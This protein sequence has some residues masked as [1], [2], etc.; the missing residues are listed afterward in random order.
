MKNTLRGIAFCAALTAC[1]PS[2]AAASVW[3]ADDDAARCQQLAK[4]DFSAIQDASSQVTEAKLVAPDGDVPAYCDVRGYVNPSVGIGLK[5]PVAN[6]NG[7][8]LEMGCGGSCGTLFSSYSENLG[9][10]CDQ[11]LRKGYA[12]VATD[13]GHQG[14]D[15]AWSKNNLQAQIDYAF[16]AVHVTSI[17]GKAIAGRYYGKAPQKSYF[18]GC[19]DGG[20]EAMNEAQKFPW[21]FDGIVSVA[22]VTDMVGFMLSGL[23]RDRVAEHDGKALFTDA[24]VE[25]LHRAVLAKCDNDDGVRDGVISNPQACRIDFSAWA[26]TATKTSECLSDAQIEALE[27]IYAGPINAKSE[28]LGGQGILPGMEKMIPT[29]PMAG[30]GG[31]AYDDW[32]LGYMQPS[33]SGLTPETFDFDSDYKR[34]ALFQAMTAA[35]NPDLSAM[36]AAGGK[37]ILAHGLVDM[38]LTASLSVDYYEKAER[39]MGGKAATQDFFRLFLVPGMDH[40]SGGP[41]A[42]AIDYLNYIEDW[43]E[44][45][46][47]PDMMVG[48]HI[49]EGLYKGWDYKLPAD[50]AAVTFT[51]PIYPYP[52]H[53]KYK[54]SGDPNDARNFEAAH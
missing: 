52:Q 7:K 26:C 30:A 19:S 53:A 22:P 29:K 8:F 42:Y 21:D 31:K 3:P 28:K 20:W 46:K 13:Q 23:W 5:L 37:L 39:T 4:E 45:G 40:C 14:T 25:W 36:K 35:K 2:L 12:C 38:A 49:Q 47:A 34:L 44:R 32:A 15:F 41:G 10:D 1:M 16:R 54:G 50:P 48:A 11:G 9:H 43:S 17:A 6:W 51:R 33:G 27:R 18:W 24:D